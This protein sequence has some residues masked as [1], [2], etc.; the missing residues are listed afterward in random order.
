MYVARGLFR[1]KASQWLRWNVL[2][3]GG[4]NNEVQTYKT[5]RV[6]SKF[7][8]ECLLCLLD[9]KGTTPQEGY[10]VVLIG[11]LPVA[12]VTLAEIDTF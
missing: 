2:G 10:Y 3:G 9:T 1:R 11:W 4:S 12:A 5:Q 7:K 6:Q 8:V